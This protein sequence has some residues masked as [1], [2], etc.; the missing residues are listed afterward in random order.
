MMSVGRSIRGRWA[1]AAA[2]VWLGTT[3]ACA[4]LGGG[5][6]A[7]REAVLTVEEARERTGMALEGKVESTTFVKASVSGKT[8]LRA[9]SS[10]PGVTFST[11]LVQF[12]DS[13]GAASMFEQ[14]E[15]TLGEGYS[16][17][18]A[19]EWLEQRHVWLVTPDGG[20]KGTMLVVQRDR[21]VAQWRIDGIR[22]ADAET[23]AKL[24]ADEVASLVDA[25]A[26]VE[27]N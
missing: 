8:T 15:S 24:F 3:L 7:A 4:G 20:A 21:F 11:E 23:L 19:A 27:S 16:R 13:A 18:P 2:A 14:A 6:G 10:V 22:V 25:P 26:P 12:E 17:Q 5:L 9:R 1:G